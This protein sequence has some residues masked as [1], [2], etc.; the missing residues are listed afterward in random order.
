VGSWHDPGGLSCAESVDS[1]ADLSPQMV[2]PSLEM[3]SWYP[4]VGPCELVDNSA[5][6][7]D[8]R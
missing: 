3:A 6:A 1:V 7:N 4:D 8:V 2:D 5:A